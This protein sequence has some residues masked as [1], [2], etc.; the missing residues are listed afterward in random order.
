MRKVI[1]I[2]LS[3]ATAVVILLP[4]VASAQFDAAALARAQRNGENVALGGTNPYASQNGEQ[5]EEQ[6]D[7][8]KTRR[9]RKPLESYYFNDSIRALP[10]FMW[11]VSREMNDVKIEPLDTTLQSWRIDYP[12]FLKGVGDMTLGGLGQSTL[13]FNYFDRNSNSDFAFAQGYD[14]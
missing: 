6:T 7:S 1:G 3:I 14:A 5:E 10:N 4:E 2:I 11:K 13:P 12:Y 9:I 8:T